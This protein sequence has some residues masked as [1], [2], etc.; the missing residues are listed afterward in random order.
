MIRLLHGPGAG[1]LAPCIGIGRDNGQVQ[2]EFPDCLVE[3][4]FGAKGEG[5]VPM[6]ILQPGIESE[7]LFGI[8]DR[9]VVVLGFEA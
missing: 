3:L 8:P 9:V 2:L 7:G 1:E 4:A 6:A 5:E